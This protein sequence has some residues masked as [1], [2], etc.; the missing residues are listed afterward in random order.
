MNENREVERE[1]AS[2]FRTL[3]E[4]FPGFR[5]VVQPFKAA[6]DRDLD[7]LI[8]VLSP[9]TKYHFAIEAKS[10]VTPQIALAV[11]DQM[12][13]VPR[14]QVRAFYS[15]VISPRVAEILRGSGIGYLDR[16]G[17][18][19]LK[20]DRLPLLIERTG[21]KTEREPTP[22]AADPFSPKSSR[23]IRLMLTDPMK[24]WQV[25]EL[26]AH[27]DVRV[28]AGL[29]VK[30]KRA[31][32]EQGYAIEYDRRLFVR[33]AVA[34]LNAWTAKYPGPAEQIDVYLRGDAANAEWT[35]HEW[36]VRNKI[37]HALCS[38]SAAW[39]LAPEVRYSVGSLYL[40]NEGFE[41]DMLERLMTECGIKR[42]ATGY[43]LSI[44]RSFD[45]SV[46]AEIP[47]GNEPK[48]S[49]LQT[50]LDL[51]KSSGRGEEAAQAV[52]ENYLSQKFALVAKREEERR[53]GET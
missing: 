38:F 34:L 35:V 10:R 8:D 15:P 5:V 46:F 25:R 43:N 27:P 19:W 45:P 53:R 47:K 16:A 24:G 44:C 18:C 52:F 9:S 21:F 3:F 50:Y 7:V 11:C 42:V 28:S 12:G 17:N 37:Q 13:K 14:T 4:G 22:A 32:I 23:I 48:T 40:A 31:L 26:A 33:D 49:A 1:A 29:V 30:V 39:K 20:S 6:Q 36:C 41:N 2:A 51:K